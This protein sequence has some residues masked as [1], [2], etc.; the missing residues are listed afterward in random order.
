M[1]DNMKT[2]EQSMP[3]LFRYFFEILAPE[4]KFYWLA[5]IYGV[6]I[7]LLTLATP[8]SV[9]MLINTVA[10][11][12]MV[13]PLVVLSLTLFTLLLIAGAMNAL[14][15][16]LMDVFGRR[17]FARMVSEI[18]LRSIYAQ[19]PFFDDRGE[20]ALFNRFFD[21]VIVIKQLPNLLVGGF[22]I[23][24]QMV[25]GFLLVSSYHPLLLAFNAAISLLI[26]LVWMIW[27]RR[28]IRSSVELS[29][30][31]HATAAWLEALGHSN[32]FYKTEQHIDDALT[33]TDEVTGRY[34]EQHSRHFG[35]H[36]A[37]TLSFLFIYALAS[38]ALLGLGGWL[39]IEGELSL[40]QLVAAELVLSAVFFGISQ[41]G[42]YLT[43]FYDVCGAVDELSLFFR[44]QQE[45]PSRA[46]K[47]LS[48]DSSLR[49]Y[50]V[51]AEGRGQ[52]IKLNF[53]VPAKAR[54]C[55]YATSHVA[56]RLFTDLVR[57]HEQPLSGYL[58]LG[59]TDLRELKAYEARREIIVLDRPNAVEAT[60]REFLRLSADNDETVDVM[61]YLGLVGLDDKVAQLP[62]GLDTKLAGTGAP[63]SITETLQLKL[64]SAMIAKPR[65]LVLSQAYDA[66]PETFLLQCMDEMQAR[67]QGTIIYFT[68]EN[69]DLGFDRYLCLGHDKQVMEE[70]YEAL[71]RDLGLSVSGLRPPAAVYGEE[72]AKFES[73]AD[74]AGIESGGGEG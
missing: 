72:A 32:G 48:G 42:T 53:E 67:C 45:L 68:Y 1:P 16:H 55:A 46:H 31:K 71:C 38:A 6:G 33:R 63:L 18:S 30:R 17:F 62:H 29:H 14:R 9:Q 66:V 41:L 52:D 69:A 12:G 43:Y 34:I 26:W 2:A 8:I 22:T 74:G 3:G 47:R 24:L 4:R 70:S 36:F 54:V 50:K 21:I 60:I 40:G 28:A 37:Q 56:Q 5:V 13:T 64:A 57:G 73:T 49:F 20:S 35:H 61:E 51:T 44:V 15:I 11:I 39:V 58:T 10:N 59:G 23:V 19:N 65:L 7:S 27:G 25:V